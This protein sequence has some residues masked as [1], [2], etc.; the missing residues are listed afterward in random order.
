MK[1]TWWI[2]KDDLRK[3]FHN[4][5]SLVVIGALLIL[6]S[7]Y[8]WFNIW[9]SWDPYERTDGIEIAVASEDEGATINDEEI[10]AG[11]E[12][13]TQ[14]S[15]NDELGWRFTSKDKVIDG[16]K[17]GD[18]YAGI[19][20][21]EDFS[22]HL[23]SVLDQEIET[24]ELD[25]Y[26]NEKVNAIAPKITDKG[27]SSIADNISENFVSETNNAVLTIFNDASV[28]L[29]E[30]YDNIEKIR[31]GIFELEDKMPSIF[32]DLEKVQDGFD[33]GDKAMDEVQGSLD[34]VDDL[35]KRMSTL[36]HTLR[37]RLADNKD[38]VHQSIGFV[39]DQLRNAQDSFQE[40]PAMTDTLSAKGDDLDSLMAKLRSKQ[41]DLDDASTRLQDVSDFLEDSDEKLKDSSNI[42][43]IQDTLDD[44]KNDLD[45]LQDDING[46]I[47]DLK[48]DDKP[49]ADVLKELSNRL[50]SV[51]S[52]VDDAHDDY[53][54]ELGP[55]LKDTQDRLSTL[56]DDLDDRFENA[57][58]RN[59]DISGKVSDLREQADDLKPDELQDRL[60]DIS[61]HL[62]TNQDWIQTVTSKLENADDLVDGSGA[63]SGLIDRLQNVEETL[64]NVQSK[65]D[66]ANDTIDDGEELGSG[67]FDDIEDALDEIGSDIDKGQDEFHDKA[68]E[69]LDEA[70][71][72]L[73]DLDGRVGERLDRLQDLGSDL[74][75]TLDKA[76]EKLENPDIA[77]SVLEHAEKGIDN[78]KNAVDD[79]G[80]RLGGLEDIIQKTD[81]SEEADGIQTIQDRLQDAKS[82]LG[83]LINQIDDTKEN[84]SDMIDRVDK[85]ASEIDDSL[86][87]MINY[88]DNTIQPKYDDLIDDTISALAGVHDVFDR[89]NDKTDDLRD[90]AGALD[91]KLDEGR[92][93]VDTLVDKFPEAEE[94]V[95]EAADK[96]RD[97]E[98]KGNLDELIDLL[99]N[100]PER[101]S[102]FIADPVK[103]NEQKMFPVPNYGSAMNP[104]YTTLA[105]W[106]GGLLLISTLKPDRRDKLE[107]KSHAMYLSRLMIFS[108]MGIIQALIAT[109]GN[110]L[111]LG[112]YVAHPVAYVLFGLFI[113]MIFV[114]IT[115]SLVSVFGNVGKVLTIVLLVIQI[116][117][118]GGTYPIEMTPDF[119]QFV[120]GFLPFTH[121][122]DLLR[123]SVGGILWHVV[124]IKMAYLSIYLIAAILLGIFGKKFFNR[125]SDKF[126]AKAEE[127][128][129]VL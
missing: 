76:S 123:E 79:V 66:D 6:P 92:D 32:S 58:D 44:N 89:L 73:D 12:V 48:N 110:L 64:E 112:T 16:V 86:E 74:N 2:L 70:E 111:M 106:V 125:T 9:Y 54:N 104:F 71:S 56:K 61:A 80:E 5:A 15:D 24:P 105:F 107:F 95:N 21:P 31:D 19:V 119:F 37:N 27:A 68:E 35:H 11:D 93:K 1:Q 98:D 116:G 75:D 20:I 82:S 128:D 8:A 39:S 42:A 34:N 129:F 49:A 25:Y 53:E 57:S 45:G 36:N 124:W 10:N 52:N 122:I 81:I 46:L 85:K 67:V 126:A 121:G 109:L 43:N 38:D 72:K 60:D 103:L 26:L 83:D 63:L 62:A 97:L 65:V 100:D 33:I 7:L 69:A 101:I 102:D 55:E 14:L 29:G 94:A 99:R 22:E 18:Y 127:S 23:A 3:I 108:A 77:L 113:G 78:A 115:Y 17:E 114:A 50:D 40:V 47:D 87:D 88:T 96:V 51:S 120:N 30:N 90:L 41:G 118:S 91:G 28:E 59:D 13:I 117:G 84:G 4:P